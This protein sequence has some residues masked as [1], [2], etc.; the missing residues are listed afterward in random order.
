MRP[1]FAEYELTQRPE[2]ITVAMASPAVLVPQRRF[3]V[4]RNP[5]DDAQVNNDVSSRL[6]VDLGW[7]GRRNHCIECVESTWRLWHMGHGLPLALNAGG[8]YGREHVLQH[9]DRVEPARGLVFTFR[10]RDDLEPLSDELERRGWHSMQEPVLLD[11]IIERTGCD[12]E[13]AVRALQHL[14]LRSPS[15]NSSLSAAP[16]HP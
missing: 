11:W 8:W 10:F 4:G 12:A 7:G 1:P 13:G 16:T 5:D 15:T 3:V 14:R 6:L 9:G 2:G